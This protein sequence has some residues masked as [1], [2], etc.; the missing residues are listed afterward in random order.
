MSVT[1][2]VTVSGEVDGD[3]VDL[4]QLT[5]PGEP[6]PF[7]LALKGFKLAWW[8]SSVLELAAEGDELRAFLSNLNIT[9]MDELRDGIVELFEAVEA[10]NAEDE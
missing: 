9:S 8:E 3:T 4:D 2:R 7:D 1:I 6:K 5:Q 10:L